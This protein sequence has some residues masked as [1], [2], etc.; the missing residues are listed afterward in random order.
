[1]HQ[2]L[3][4][5]IFSYKFRLFANLNQEVIKSWGQGAF[6]RKVSGNFSFV[7]CLSP[8]NKGR[9]VKKSVFRSVSFGLKSSK[10]SLLSSQNLNCGSWIFSKSDQATRLGDKLGTNLWKHKTLVKRKSNIVGYSTFSPMSEV[11]LGATKIILFLRNSWIFVLNSK[12]FRIL[13]QS[14]MMVFLIRKSIYVCDRESY[15]VFIGIGFEIEEP[16]DPIKISLNN[17]KILLLSK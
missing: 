10:Q 1:M 15:K 8:S 7:F 9:V 16:N 3:F 5:L 6:V 17:P 12:C 14:S 4:R 13:L 11:K 2:W